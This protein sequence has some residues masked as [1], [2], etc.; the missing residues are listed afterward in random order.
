VTRPLGERGIPAGKDRRAFSSQGSQECAE[1]GHAKE[2][3]EEES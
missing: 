3:E 1:K 2:A